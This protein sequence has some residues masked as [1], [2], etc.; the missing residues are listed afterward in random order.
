M[1][2]AGVFRQD[3]GKRRPSPSSWQKTSGGA[4][5]GGR[6]PMFAT[7]NPAGVSPRHRAT[8]KAAQSLCPL[9]L[10]APPHS[11]AP[12]RAHPFSRSPA[13]RSAMAA[14]RFSTGS[15]SSCS[16]GDRLALVGRN[17]SG[18]STLMKVMAGL[19]EADAGARVLP[20]GTR[21]GYLEQDPDFSGFATLGDFAT[22]RIGPPR[23]G[24]WRRRPRGSTSTSPP[25]PTGLGR[26]AA[27]RGAGA[28]PGRGARPDA[29]R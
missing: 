1:P 4:E 16:A 13:S 27:A 22:A 15:T 20:E 12:W 11:S 23:P 25:A 24:A 5:G 21:V 7:E 8:P 9:T 14:R 6:A 29:A 19:V 17:G 18:K 26:G 3:E 28:A 2:P 10:V